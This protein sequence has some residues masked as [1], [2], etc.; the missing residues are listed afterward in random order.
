MTRR[1]EAAVRGSVHAGMTLFTPTQRK[2]FQI[3]SLNPNDIVL[4]LGEMKTP[5]HLEW[6]CLEGIPDYLGSKARWVEIGGRYKVE[7]TPDTL[8]AYLKGCV[9]RATAGWVAALLAH[10]GVVEIRGERPAFVRLT[11]TFAHE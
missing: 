3:G 9:N 4:L 11:T 2:P 1:V 10:A 7:G 6:D 8:D 5:T